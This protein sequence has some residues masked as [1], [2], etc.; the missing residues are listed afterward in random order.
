MEGT[1]KGNMTFQIMDVQGRRVMAGE[2]FSEG[3]RWSVDVRALTDGAY[4]LRGVMGATVFQGRFVVQ[5]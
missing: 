4:V 3:T 5:H 1:P 2:R